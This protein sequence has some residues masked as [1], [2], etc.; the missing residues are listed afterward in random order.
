MPLITYRLKQRSRPVGRGVTDAFRGAV[1]AIIKE[2]HFEAP[3]QTYNEHVAQRLAGLIGVPTAAGALVIHGT[4]LKYASLALSDLSATP[5]DI[6]SDRQIQ[7]TLARYPIECAA[8]L[9]F[10][11]WIGNPDRT[12]NVKANL[13]A[14]H[15]DLLCAFDHG[16]ALLGCRGNKEDSIEALAND[17]G[18]PLHHPFAAGVSR[19]DCMV[20]VERIQRLDASLIRETCV[21]GQSVGS[22]FPPE[23]EE[24]AVALTQRRG[25]LP[26]IVQRIVKEGQV[27][28]DIT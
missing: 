20:T 25:R 26:E 14:R 12:G 10:D 21:A 16:L 6:Q 28:C 8:I 19:A 7:R 15:D 1:E 23:Q 18:W 2:D 24:L 22:V 5:P 9:V 17:V 27:P 3:T 13:A 11:L 4:G